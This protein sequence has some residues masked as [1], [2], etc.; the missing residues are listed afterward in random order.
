MILFQSL[1]REYSQRDLKLGRFIRIFPPSFDF[2]KPSPCL[3]DND[4]GIK[5]SKSIKN[6]S[7]NSSHF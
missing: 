4:F 5:K 7:V 3:I 6:I 2:L 1:A